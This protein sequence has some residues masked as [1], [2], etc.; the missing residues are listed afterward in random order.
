MTILINKT[1]KINT[2]QLEKQQLFYFDAL[3]HLVP[4][5]RHWQTSSASCRRL[6]LLVKFSS[7]PASG[8]GNCIFFPFTSKVV[9]HHIGWGT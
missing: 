4:F 9:G 6:V 8:R 2:D 1:D 5:R 7:M 3:E